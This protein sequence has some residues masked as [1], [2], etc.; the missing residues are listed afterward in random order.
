MRVGFA[1]LLRRSALVRVY[2]PAVPQVLACATGGPVPLHGLKH[3][4]P[5]SLYG[6]AVSHVCVRALDGPYGRARLWPAPNTHSVL[7]AL[8]AHVG[9]QSDNGSDAPRVPGRVLG[10]WSADA[11]QR[12]GRGSVLRGG[13]GCGGWT[14]G[15]A[16]VVAF[17]PAAEVPGVA[18]VTDE[19][20]SRRRTFM[21]RV[22]RAQYG[23]D[24]RPDVVLSLL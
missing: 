1:E 11:G 18:S 7:T 10:R 20:C 3:D 5:S 23:P 4:P 6:H 16:G 12:S 15:V 9:F 17:L 2:D 24:G 21:F 19:D 14:V 13:S 22:L 8:A